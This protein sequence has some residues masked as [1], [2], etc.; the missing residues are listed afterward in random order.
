MSISANNTIDKLILFVRVLILKTNVDRK[1]YF[2]FFNPAWERF[3]NN[4]VAISVNSRNFLG[5]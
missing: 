1:P 4:I 3:L 5:V 2:I